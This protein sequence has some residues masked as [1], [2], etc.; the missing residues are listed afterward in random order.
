M[1]AHLRNLYVHYGEWAGIRVARKH[2]AWYA[3]GRPHADR[4]RLA[5]M[6]TDSTAAQ[7]DAVDSYFES[8]AVSEAI[9]TAA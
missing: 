7:L 6:Q 9:Q 2:I 3:R 5:I 8:L 1:R 4:F